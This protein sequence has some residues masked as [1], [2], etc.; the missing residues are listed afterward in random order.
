[1]KITD[2]PDLSPRMIRQVARSLAFNMCKLRELKDRHY[3]GKVIA[4][5]HVLWVAGVITFAQ[6][7]RILNLAM[8][9]AHGRNHA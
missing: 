6:D 2:T 8:K 1:M 7:T 3:S 9:L 5:S 4:L